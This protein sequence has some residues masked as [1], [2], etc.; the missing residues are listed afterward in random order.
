ML[1]SYILGII[2]AHIIIIPSGIFSFISLVLTQIINN[3]DTAV[4]INVY[5]SSSLITYL[6]FSLLSKH[7]INKLFKLCW[8]SGLLIIPIV[9]QY[10]S[11]ID[12]SIS[13]SFLHNLY[14][15][16]YNHYHFG[17]ALTFI[18]IYILLQIT[19]LTFYYI[20]IKLRNIANK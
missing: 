15:R 8:I 2:F 18:I 20:F 19:T 10:F 9:A 1:L 12:H 11:L 7:K 13:N 14:Y 17:D 3:E 5:V 16:Y 4:L 6:S